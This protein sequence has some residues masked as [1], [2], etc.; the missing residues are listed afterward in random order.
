MAEER[1][2]QGLQDVIG[3]DAGDRGMK[4]LIVPGDL[5]AAGRIFA[6]LPTGS[7]VIVLSGFPC[8]VDQ[9]PP[10]E[11]VRFAFFVVFRVTY[12]FWIYTIR[13]KARMYDSL[14]H[15]FFALAMI[16]FSHLYRMGLPV[17]WQ[18]LVPVSLS[19]TKP[20]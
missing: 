8:C 16:Y 6:K 1:I 17:L 13:A 15:S 3:T 20:F 19:D 7:T 4:T 2:I 12:Y 18:L 11:T 5:L 14:S 10:T 9:T